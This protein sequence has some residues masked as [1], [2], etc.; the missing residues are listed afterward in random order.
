MDKQI[1]AMFREEARRIVSKDRSARKYG[2]SNNLPGDITG[3]L[4]TAYKLGL[5]HGESP[6]APKPELPRNDASA[7]WELVPPTS[8]TIL[9][10]LTFSYSNRG[11]KATF[12][13]S[14]LRG[15]SDPAT[16]RQRWAWVDQGGNAKGDEHSFA[17]KGIGPLLRMEL[18]TP[19]DGDENHLVLTP[20]G[21]ATCRLYWSRSDRND[22]TLPIQS[23]GR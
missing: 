10:Y 12:I 11:A 3:A 5:E 16:G 17:T 23:M 18:L 20:K 1:K 7:A 6:D 2:A 13:P 9:S 8:R 14:E 22:P 21:D 4:V 19:K 15:Y